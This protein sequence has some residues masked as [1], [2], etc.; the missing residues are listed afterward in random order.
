MLAMVKCDFTATKSYLSQIVV[1]TIVIA[2]LIWFGTGQLVSGLAALAAMLPFMYIFSIAA[3]DELNGWERFRLTLPITRRQTV[4]GRYVSILL[5]VIASDVLMLAFACLA[6][7][8]ATLLPQFPA[9]ESVLASF[10]LGAELSHAILVSAIMLAVAAVSMPP[11]MRF[12][13][14]KG[15]RFVP[16]LMIM[17]IVGVLYMVG[18]S[19]D[20]MVQ[21]LPFLE[22]LLVPSANEVWASLGMS[23][24]AFA[25]AFVVYAL[26][27]LLSV[28]L[29]EKR[30]F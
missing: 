14:T 8:V 10:S 29:Y 2:F 13:M 11:F 1:I 16:L 24:I 27:A 3:Y 12:G 19:E 7:L 23:G 17:I 18:V 28:K 20:A 26:S 6:Y 25:I 22:T 15:V 9:T 4:L 30:Q 21:A 5:V